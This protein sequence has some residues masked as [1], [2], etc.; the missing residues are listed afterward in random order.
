MRHPT[1]NG[2]YQAALSMKL[3]SAIIILDGD[4]QLQVSG[5]DFSHGQVNRHENC[6]TAGLS[7]SMI[8][9]R[10]TWYAQLSAAASGG[11]S[12]LIHLRSKVLI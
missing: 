8:Q 6:Q 10:Q 11:F 7:G 9:I 3:E 12:L 4:W 5:S 1:S 2:S